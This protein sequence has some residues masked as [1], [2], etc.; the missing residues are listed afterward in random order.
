MGKNL[1]LPV[2]GESS[3]YPGMRPK[4][5][6]TMPDGKLMV[7]KS[8]ELF[9]LNEFSR[10]VVVALKEHVDRYT[11]TK[12][13]SKILQNNFSKKIELVQLKNETT[14]QAE[15]VLQG[16]LKSN[17]KGGFI[18]KDVDNIFSQ[19]I[20]KKN[21]NQI[22]TINSKKI[23]LLDAKSK[24][25]ID[26]NKMGKVTNIVE[27]KVISDFF[28]CGAYE[29]KSVKEFIF[30]ARK[31]LKI[32]KDV[33]ISDV[34]Y[35]MLLD[36]HY[37]SF[38]EGSDYIDWGTLREFRNF[39]KKYYTIFC[40]FDGCLIENSSKFAKKPWI[41]NPINKNIQCIQKLQKIIKVELIITTSRAS[42]ER[43]KIVNFL[44]ENNIK[45]KTIITDLMHSKRILV[46]DFA[47]SNPY[48]SSIAVNISRNNIEL[49]SVLESII[50]NS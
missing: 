35:S 36:N 39:H 18:V 21:I 31:C 27:K 47:N 8:V 10:V 12:V 24:S 14:C 34:I 29:F 3:R 46:N 23:E 19:K 38:L 7:E 43:K 25:Y 33:F 42:S 2:A 44:R 32:S 11:S 1:I 28:C 49:S 17:A 9:D 41:I 50:Y 15:T 45:F 6:L 5:L 22:T 20:G 48:P 13:L 30:Y 26:F 37:F 40:D 4:W 16:L